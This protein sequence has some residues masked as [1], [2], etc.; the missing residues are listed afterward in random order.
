MTPYLKNNRFKTMVESKVILKKIK[1]VGMIALLIGAI[2]AIGIC[3]FSCVGGMAATGWSGGV[4]DN[5]VLYVGSMEGRL[6]RVDLTDLSILR[7]EPLKLASQGGLFGSCSSML[8]CG[9][10][11]SRVPIYGTPVVSGNFVYIAAYNGRIYAYNTNNLGQ[12]WFFPSEGY[13][14]SLV[15]SLVIDQNRLFIG[16][17]DGNIYSLDATTGEKL[18]SYKTGDKIWGTPIVA[19]NTLYIGSF[20]KTLYALDTATLT[21]KWTFATQGSIIA[22]P[23]VQNGVVYIGSFDKM[24]YAI[25]AADGTEKWKYMAT[26][27]FWTQPIIV[28]DVIYAGCLDGNV[29][30]LNVNN[31][32]LIK[33]FDIPEIFTMP[34]SGLA[35]QPVVVDKYVIFATQNGI[36]YKIDTTSQEITLVEAL[37][38]SID[39]PMMAYKGIIY[40]Q[41]Q[42]VAIQRIEIATGTLF[43]SISLLSG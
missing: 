1:I 4:V 36:I 43:P 42:D 3:G 35:S 22:K 41:T 27:W 18:A 34:R 32:E 38:G 5:D 31:G 21:P 29:Y 20:D 39:G 2:L 8:S 25:N 16:C 40:F 28:G 26:N 14:S 19:D 33:M 10:G 13:L 37:T 15:G 30:A 9:G 7:A 17:S 11:S 24:L 23:L 12:K 6:A